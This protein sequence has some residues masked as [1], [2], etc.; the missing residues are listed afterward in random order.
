VG[1]RQA[2]KTTLVRNAFPHKPYVSLEDLDVQ[3]LAIADPRAFLAGYPQGAILDEIQRAPGLLSY[4]QGIVDEKK[5]PALFILTGS[6][7][8][9]LHQAVSQSLAGR[10]ALLHLLPMSLQ[11]LNQAGFDLSLDEFLLRGGY[12]RIYADQLNPTKAYRNYF[13]TYVE[14]DLRQISQIADLAQFQKFIKLCAGRI[15]Q[16]V[17]LESIG[18]EV[19]I[20]SPTVRNW[21]S[22]LEASYMIVRLSPYFENFGKRMVKAPKIYFTDVGFA[23]YLLGIETLS[24][25]QRD[26]L[27]GHLVENLLVLELMKARLNQGLDPHLYFFRDA[28]GHEVDLIYQSGHALIP[29]E[30]KASQTFQKEM[31]KNIQFF[32]NLCPERAF[33]G[34]LIYAG[35]QEQKIG[36]IQLIHFT[37]AARMIVQ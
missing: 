4:I 10:T 22:I 1:P 3:E 8:M 15:G 21:L 7:Q 23:A 30:I 36:S 35:L 28:H 2:G 33:Q 24:Q 20:S 34:Y 16:L 11:E 12:P 18:N 14:R 31:L 32:Q 13:Q 9:E 26:P 37:N 19:G 29:I 6:H 25:I 27:R 17:N 5:T